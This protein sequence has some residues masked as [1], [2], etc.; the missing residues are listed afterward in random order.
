MKR[1][2]LGFD[3][4]ISRFWTAIQLTTADPREVRAQY[5]IYRYPVT[6]ESDIEECNSP[7][8][9]HQRPDTLYQPAEKNKK[10]KFDSHDCT[11]AKRIHG[12][13]PFMKRIHFLEKICGKLY[14]RKFRN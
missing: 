3:V 5:E 12:G 14:I 7:P 9:Y 13:D 1:I 10:A 4:N 6:Q 2:A 8:V 11:P